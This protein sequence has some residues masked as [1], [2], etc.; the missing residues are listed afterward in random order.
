MR[1]NIHKKARK[2]LGVSFSKDLC[3]ALPGF[4]YSFKAARRAACFSYSCIILALRL[5]HS[6][7]SMA[8]VRGAPPRGQEGLPG[9]IMYS[10]PS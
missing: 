3:S 1:A 8:K 6:A 7:V 2:Y 5:P 9:L 4:F 10:L